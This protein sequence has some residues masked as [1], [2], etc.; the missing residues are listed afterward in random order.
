[1][2]L[3]PHSSAHAIK[4]AKKAHKAYD[5]MCAYQRVM[6]HKATP[7]TK[8]KKV[9]PPNGITIHNIHPICPKAGETHQCSSS[10]FSSHHLIQK[11]HH[12]HGA[13]FVGGYM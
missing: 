3:A 8:D 9:M 2:V 6:H 12:A 4:K 10:R 1:M 13:I 7:F 11:I 5:T